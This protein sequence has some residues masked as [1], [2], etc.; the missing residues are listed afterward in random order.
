[1]SPC[2]RGALFG[3]SREVRSLVL[4]QGDGNA[5]WWL[6]RM[7]HEYPMLCV[8]VQAGYNSMSRTHENCVDIDTDIL[9]CPI[10]TRYKT[11]INRRLAII[12][13]FSN[14]DEAEVT[15]R[16]G[17]SLGSFASVLP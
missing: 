7:G 3:S 9:I 6:G 8:S 11:L 15:L 10:L 17:T 2:Q 4:A 1:M 13:P 5:A 14:D 12:Q 16:A